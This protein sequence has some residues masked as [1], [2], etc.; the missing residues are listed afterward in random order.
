MHEILMSISMKH[1]LQRDFHIYQE[2]IFGFLIT[3]DS[4]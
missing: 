3:A 4:D 2:L 1:K